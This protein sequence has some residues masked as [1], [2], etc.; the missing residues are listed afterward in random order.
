MS[1][2]KTFVELY[3]YYGG[4]RALI[5]SFFFWISILLTIGSRHLAVEGSEIWIKHS[6]AILP[7]LAGF[8]VASFALFF[9]VLDERQRKLLLTPI[10]EM[11][12]KAPLIVLS[13]SAFHCLFIQISALMYA[14]MYSSKPFPSFGLDERTVFIINSVFSVLG[15]FLFLY[16][17]ILILSVLSALFRLFTIV[18][19]SSN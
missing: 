13:T 6:I 4:F 17:V 11:D 18:G 9:A 16:G 19:N 14:I 15:L 3:R 1:S 2:I 12:N 7:S 5:S 8:T 10:A